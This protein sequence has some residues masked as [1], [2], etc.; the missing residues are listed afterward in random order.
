MLGLCLRKD[1]YTFLVKSSIGCSIVTFEQN[2]QIPAIKYGD[3]PFEQH[4]WQF[5]PIKISKS[6]SKF[7]YQKATVKTCSHSDISS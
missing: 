1:V 6:Q 2:S 7:S 4:F 5:F 3:N